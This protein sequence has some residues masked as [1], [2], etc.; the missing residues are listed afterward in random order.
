LHDARR[1]QIVAANGV[2]ARLEDGS[3][4]HALSRGPRP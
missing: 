4:F 2:L 1:A 3:S